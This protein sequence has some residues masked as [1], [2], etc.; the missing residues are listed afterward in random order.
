MFN[1]LGNV[2]GSLFSRAAQDVVNAI[3]IVINTV[4]GTFNGY[5]GYWHTI[6]G[7]VIARWKSL[8]YSSGVAYTSIR[9]F[10]AAVYA[11]FVYIERVQFKSV[12]AQINLEHARMIHDVEAVEAYLIARTDAEIAKEHSYARSILLWVLIHVLAFLYGLV[13]AIFTW[14]ANQGA[15]MWHYFTHLDEFAK[16]LLDALV[17]AFE[18]ASWDI[19]PKLGQFFLSLIVRNV[20]RFATLVESIVDAVL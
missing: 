4:Q 5:Y 10:M 1:W 19:A 2:F 6:S 3:S 15:T 14:L 12:V 11:R 18:A 7:R 13:K 20:V 9:G 17:L 8:A 16:L